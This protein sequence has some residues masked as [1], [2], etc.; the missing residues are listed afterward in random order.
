MKNILFILLLCQ[1]IWASPTPSIIETRA[2]VLFVDKPATISINQIQFSEQGWQNWRKTLESSDYFAQLEKHHIQVTTNFLGVESI[3]EKEG[4]WEA[5]ARLMVNYANDVY[6]KAMFYDITLHLI[7]KDNDF[8]IDRY[9]L[10]Q[11]A[12]PNQGRQIPKCELKDL[13]Q[14]A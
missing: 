7:P 10:N 8:V 6:Y 12:E 3:T 13:S 5:K 1:S 9:E 11:Y 2:K 14:A 4:G